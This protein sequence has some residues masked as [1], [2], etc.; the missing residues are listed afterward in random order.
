MSGMPRG[1]VTEE[2]MLTF[3]R[4]T[5][6]RTCHSHSAEEGLLVFLQGCVVSQLTQPNIHSACLWLLEY[7]QKGQ[8][9]L[10]R[11]HCIY[12]CIASLLLLSWER[13]IFILR[14]SELASLASLTTF[15]SAGILN[16]VRVCC[17]HIFI[18]SYQHAVH[19]AMFF[20]RLF[21]AAIHLQ[22]GW[23]TH[24]RTAIYEQWD[25]M[26]QKL[27]LQN[28]SPVL[29]CSKNIISRSRSRFFTFFLIT[30]SP[31]LLGI[32]EDIFNTF[33]NTT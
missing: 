29:W 14:T 21:F 28:I 15:S 32:R 4:R 33:L 2:M 24:S 8:T 31:Q 22:S 9:L 25:E 1:A 17:L 3:K 20:S 7:W 19:L 10:Q 30:Y 23:P 12:N 6:R 27:P 11:R 18:P 13:A 16:L 5:V 26:K